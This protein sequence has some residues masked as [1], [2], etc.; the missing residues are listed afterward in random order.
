MRKA[1]SDGVVS[2]HEYLVR[3]VMA[4]LGKGDAVCLIVAMSLRGE[5]GHASW[6]EIVCGGLVL[7]L[8]ESWT[9]CSWSGAMGT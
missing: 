8:S 3:R 5:E 6:M 9:F 2:K 4:R 7:R 1:S